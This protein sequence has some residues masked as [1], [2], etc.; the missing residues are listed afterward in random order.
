[1]S[2]HSRRSHTLPS[3]LRPFGAQ[4]HGLVLFGLAVLL[5]VLNLFFPHLVQRVRVTLTD[6]FAPLLHMAG[7]PAGALEGMQTALQNA[8][9]MRTENEKLRKDLEALQSLRT[10]AQQYAEENRNLK[11]LLKYKDESVEEALTARVIGQTGGN[12]TESVIITAGTRDGVVENMIAMN[13]DGV[14][15]RVIE[16]GTWSSRVLLL[17]DFSFRLPV[18]LEDTQQRAILSGEGQDMP[19]LLF[20]PQDNALKPGVRVVTSG[21]GGLFPPY[22]PV[23]MVKEIKGHDVRV[24]PLARLDRLH[25]IRLA[26]YNLAGGTQNPMNAELAQPAGARP[27][28]GETPVQPQSA[29]LPKPALKKGP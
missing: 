19:R 8:G 4:I 16:V 15:G 28:G 6:A 3:F 23:G 10:L 2:R 27:E 9:D 20:L 25:I 18:M 29:P 12:F 13:E 11:N 17:N 26:R 7:T 21:H 14:V 24:M 1:M 5:V 22:L